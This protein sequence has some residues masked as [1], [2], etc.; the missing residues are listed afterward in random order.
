[1]VIA[2]VD[3]AGRG[4]VFG[5][6]VIAGVSVESNSIKRLE[7]L[8]L[9][10][11]KMLTPG[12]RETLSKKIEKIAKD[13]II[14]KVGACKID[15]YRK[16]GVDLN[17]L[18]AM[19]FAEIISY[20]NPSFCYVDCPDTVP[21]RLEKYLKTMT[22]N[23]GSFFVEHKADEN[24]PIV[25]AASIIAK[26]TRDAEVKKICKKHCL[27]NIGSGYPHDP[28]TVQWMKKWI[29]KNKEFPDY[30]RK[31]WVT[32]ELMIAEKEQ[33]KLGQWF[34]KLKKKN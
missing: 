2:G 15:T 13:I 11:S 12:Q 23:S 22:K 16:Q 3:E 7:G 5:D 19:K 14:I 6:L 8:K 1:M 9:K 29:E 31:S 18:E 4:A 26:V 10:D 24:Y 17:K 25:S 32:S 20:L 30:V 27:G 28:L 34:G 21:S 33:S